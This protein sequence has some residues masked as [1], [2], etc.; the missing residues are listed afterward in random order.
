MNLRDSKKRDERRN[1]ELME[2]NMKEVTEK[3]K[4]I[5]DKN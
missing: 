1:N 2:K 3:V 4:E 5:Q